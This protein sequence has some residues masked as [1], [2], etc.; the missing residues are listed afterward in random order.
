M[1]FWFE[2]MHQRG[3]EGERESV[4]DPYLQMQLVWL[5]R[6]KYAC[7]HFLNLKLAPHTN[8]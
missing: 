8:G 4:R 5:T 3:G 6:L 2:S 7:L 1:L